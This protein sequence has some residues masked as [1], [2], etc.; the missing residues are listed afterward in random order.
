[1][2]IILTSVQVTNMQNYKSSIGRY[3]VWICLHFKTFTRTRDHI[4]YACVRVAY[5]HSLLAKFL[6]RAHYRV[7]MHIRV[8]T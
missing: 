5:L 4:E 3:I 7:Y 1:M 2:N 6:I 8:Y